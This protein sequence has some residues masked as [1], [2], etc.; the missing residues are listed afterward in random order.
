MVY[1]AKTRLLRTV[2]AVRTW[3]RANQATFYVPTLVA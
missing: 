2:E 1:G 3:I